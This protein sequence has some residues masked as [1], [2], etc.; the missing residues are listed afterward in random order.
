MVEEF[1]EK[2]VLRVHR[3]Q[4]GIQEKL[5]FKTKI[6]TPELMIQ[7]LDLAEIITLIEDRFEVSPF[8]SDGQLET[9]QDMV[10]LVRKQGF[11]TCP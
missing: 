2:A 10:A 4:G 1:I 5:D 6:L 11:E 3:R 7:S 8:E 9:W